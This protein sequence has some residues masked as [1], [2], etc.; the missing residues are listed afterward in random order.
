MRWFWRLPP[1]RPPALMPTWASC[2]HEPVHAV[3]GAHEDDR[4]AVPVGDLGGHRELVVAVHLEHVVL[5]GVDRGGGRGHRVGHR[6]GQEAAD[7]LV[8]VT[9]EGGGEQQTLA[10]GRGLLQDRA[11]DGEEAEVAHVV[12]LVEDRHLDLV[13]H[14]LT[15]L[16]EVGQAA[17][18]GHDDLDTAAQ[19]LD[20]ATH[21]HAADD[22]LHPQR[23]AAAEGLQ[24]VGHLH[25]ELAGRNQH[26]GQRVTGAGLGAGDAGHHGQAEGERLAGAG[27]TAAENVVTCEDVGDRGPLDGEGTVDARTGETGDQG[28]RQA[29]KGELGRAGGGRGDFGDF[30]QNSVKHGH[31]DSCLSI[32][33]RGTSLLRKD[34]PGT[35]GLRPHWINTHIGAVVR[36]K[37]RRTAR[38]GSSLPARS[39]TTI[40]HT[41][42]SQCRVR[43]GRPA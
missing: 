19:R 32:E 14:A 13:Q 31:E 9:V 24:G 41:R 11:D 16:H 37:S 40:K 21:R 15:L 18:G 35:R 28:L 30:G 4:T 25:G 39:Q 7:Q 26:D 29:E 22:G 27:L 2:L 20:L 5:H 10:V 42:R 6:V 38:G 43:S 33:E 36:C 23:Q 8:H 12:G 34:E 1:C 17:G 3:L